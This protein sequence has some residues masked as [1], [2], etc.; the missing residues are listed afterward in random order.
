MQKG[1]DFVL[2]IAAEDRKGIVAAVANSIASQDCNIVESSQY[3]DA[4]TGRF[5]MRVAIS[6]PPGM[7]TE[8]FTEGFTPVATAYRLDWRINN[9]AQKLRV[10]IMSARAATV[11]TTCSIALRPG[12]CR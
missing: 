3:G 4:N 5:F 12:D 9:L 7:T 1:A 8:N 10:M 11:S 2:M 6:V